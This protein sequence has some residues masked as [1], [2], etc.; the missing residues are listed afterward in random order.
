MSKPFKSIM[1]PNKKVEVNVEAL[2]VEE[3]GVGLSLTNL[4]WSVTTAMI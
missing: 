1:D 3:E 4:A 2:T